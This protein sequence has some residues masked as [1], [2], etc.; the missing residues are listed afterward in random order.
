MEGNRRLERGEAVEQ[1]VAS[2]G[3]DQLVYQHV[4]QLR[5][6]CRQEPHALA[7]TPALALA[8]PLGPSLSLSPNLG[9]GTVAPNIGEREQLEGTEDLLRAQPCHVVGRHKP[10]NRPAGAHLGRRELRREIVRCWRAQGV[11]RLALGAKLHLHQ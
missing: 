6:P 5:R 7:P 11:G 3:A 10:R 2:T 9:L 1:Q 4:A 8:L